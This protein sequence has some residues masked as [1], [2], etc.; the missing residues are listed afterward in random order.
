MLKL[1]DHKQTAT[2]PKTGSDIEESKSYQPGAALA[3]LDASIAAFREK[4][5]EVHDAFKGMLSRQAGNF[6]HAKD[7]N[8]R[9]MKMTAQQAA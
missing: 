6:K 8:D 5:N 3:E 4:M 7:Y 2:A 9:P 1:I